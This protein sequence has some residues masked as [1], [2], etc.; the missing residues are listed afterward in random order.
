MVKVT[1]AAGALRRPSA[2]P[3]GQGLL[4]AARQNGELLRS[5]G[6]ALALIELLVAHESLG[7]TEAARLLG[8]APSTAHRLLTTFVAEG[9]AMRSVEVDGRYRRGPAL[10]R[11]LGRATIQ[12]SLLREAAHAILERVAARS[13]E[14][15]HLT[16]LD[17]LDAVG[18]D[19]VESSR[20]VVARHPIGSRMPAHATAVG[21]ALLAFAPEVAE[22]LIAEGLTRHTG[23]TVE[24]ARALRRTLAEVRRRGYALNLRGWHEETAGVAAPV[25]DAGGIAIASACD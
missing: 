15:A 21:Q 19:H 12:P 9:F 17:G 11:F 7:V 8:V 6:N 2:D 10:V 16:V 3:F 18:V 23:Q 24:D 20:P 14:T 22:A 25:L 5:V 1:P 4:P 13:G